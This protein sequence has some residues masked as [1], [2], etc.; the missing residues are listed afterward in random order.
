MEYGV[1]TQM[2]QDKRIKRLLDEHKLRSYG[3]FRF[4]VDEI[5]LAGGK[6]GKVSMSD[7]NFQKKMEKICNFSFKYVEG[8]IDDMVECGL[9]RYCTERGETVTEVPENVT[10]YV[11]LLQNE[12]LF[13]NL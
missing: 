5:F 3:V 9:L 13:T 12:T 6:E 10:K 4:V 11:A 2:F 7:P 8:Y 1:S